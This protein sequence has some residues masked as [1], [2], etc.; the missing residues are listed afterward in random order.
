MVTDTWNLNIRLWKAG[1]D[2][3]CHF[4]VK[5]PWIFTFDF[6]INETQINMLS[7]RCKIKVDSKGQTIAQRF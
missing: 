7:M 6:L 1:R 4:G 5:H 2:V 3:L